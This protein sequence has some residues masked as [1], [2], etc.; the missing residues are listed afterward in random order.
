MNIILLEDVKSLGKKGD[1]VK[2]SD[3][4]ARNFIL[5]RK[6]GIE[7][8]EKNKND[9]RLQKKHEEKLAAERLAA[10]QELGKKIEAIDVSVGVKGGTSGKVFGSVTA[11]EIAA[12]A[13][14]QHGLELDKKKIQLGEP[15]KSFGT[16]EVP[17]KLHPQVTAKLK[18]NVVQK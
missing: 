18:V 6:L 1:V 8:T 4:Y 7:A 12:A 10:A 15:I 11:K 16:Y 14:A 17:V 13:K 2:V 3:G 5:P 9:L